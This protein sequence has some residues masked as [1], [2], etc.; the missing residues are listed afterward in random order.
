MLQRVDGHD[1]VGVHHDGRRPR[2]VLQVG[3]GEGG[4][5]GGVKVARQA[6]GGHGCV[7]PCVVIQK[8]NGIEVVHNIQTVHA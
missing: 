7:V 5:G 2:H 4:V 8:R 3:V 6:V 1:V